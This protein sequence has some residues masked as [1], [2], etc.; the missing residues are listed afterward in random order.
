MQ[1]QPCGVLPHLAAQSETEQKE[2][3][4]STTF[5]PSCRTEEDHMKK[6]LDTKSQTVAK[7]VWTWIWIKYLS[8]SGFVLLKLLF[9]SYFSRDVT[10]LLQ[11]LHFFF[12]Q[13]KHNFPY[14]CGRQCTRK[15][16]WLSQTKDEPSTQPSLHTNREQ[17]EYSNHSILTRSSVNH[18]L[19][20]I[21]Y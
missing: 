13:M 19:W 6:M 12:A 2:G 16:A 10:H 21:K 17:T 9:W 1:D 11:L 7:P 4:K 15:S 3:N 14:Y 18:C 5:S 8:Y 20:V